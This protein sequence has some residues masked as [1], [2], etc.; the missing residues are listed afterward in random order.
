MKLMKIISIMVS[1]KNDIGKLV[2]GFDYFDI[3]LQNNVVINNIKP[4]ND[5][6]NDIK[7][8]LIKNKNNEEEVEEEEEINTNT[9]ASTEKQTKKS[10]NLSSH[11]KLFYDKLNSIKGNF[12]LFRT[13][14]G[15]NGFL[16]NDERNQFYILLL[17]TGII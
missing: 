12:K 17:S 2:N 9:N 3:N 11:D 5:K 4:K 7:E 16:R 8:D 13:F 1:L 15:H 10:S 14:A 6:D